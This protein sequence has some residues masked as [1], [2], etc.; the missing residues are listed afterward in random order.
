MGVSPVSTAFTSARAEQLAHEAAAVAGL[1]AGRAELIRLGSTA[2]L[3]LPGGVVARVA[4]DESWIETSAH[5]VRVAAALYRTGVPCVRPWP[6]RQPVT[7]DGHP[8][9]FWA[10]IP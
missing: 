3:R 5:E 1:A 8:V 10:E 9:T 7:V 4:R 6:V 2:V